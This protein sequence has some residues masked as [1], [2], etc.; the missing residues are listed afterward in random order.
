MPPFH[1]LNIIAAIEIKW[2]KL[3]VIKAT[4]TDRPARSTQPPSARQVPVIANVNQ[5]PETSNPVHSDDSL[6]KT[7]A[8]LPAV[9]P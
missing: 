4:P 5:A 2:S 3:L 7:R 9:H 1:Q 8:A 6:R